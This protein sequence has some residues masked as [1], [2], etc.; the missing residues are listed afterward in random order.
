[1]YAVLAEELLTRLCSNTESTMDDKNSP[2]LHA[3]NRISNSAILSTNNFLI[4]NLLLLLAIVC[5]W[6]VIQGCM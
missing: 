6:S 5:Y 3:H 2:C 1:M 4:A